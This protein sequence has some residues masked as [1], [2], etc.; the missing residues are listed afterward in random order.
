[1]AP[2]LKVKSSSIYF[3]IFSIFSHEAP[4]DR[5]L[6]KLIHHISLKGA[7]C[8]IF[9]KEGYS[10]SGLTHHNS[11]F[12]CAWLTCLIVPSLRITPLEL[13]IDSTS[14]LS[15]F[16]KFHN[17]I[18]GSGCSEDKIC[19]RKKDFFLTA[20]IISFYHKCHFPL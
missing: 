8:L 4:F 15:L 13:D 20:S 1:M 11:V 17:S 7:I 5:N 10:V 18:F 6:K 9:L 14:I 19:I 3:G 2:L 12:R 16:E